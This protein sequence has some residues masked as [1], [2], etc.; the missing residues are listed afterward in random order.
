MQKLRQEIT[1]IILAYKSTHIIENALDPIVNQGFNIK[2]IDNGSNDNIADLLKEKYANSGI[3]LIMLENNV[4]FSRG[5][6]VALKKVTT[7][8]AFLLN[9]D[10]IIDPESID[11]LALEMEKDKNIAL[12][13]PFS[14]TNLDLTLEEK[15]Q[16]I[17]N[18][19]KT[20]T[21]LNED[22]NK[23]ETDFICGGYMLIKT[24]I[25]QKIGFLDENLFLYYDDNEISSRSI[26]NNYKNILIKNS[27]TVHSNQ[28]SVKTNNKIQEYKMIYFRS[29]HMGWSKS[30][31]KNNKSNFRIL[32]KSFY[33]IL[34]SVK[35]L[36]RLDL[37][38]FIKKIGTSIG[39]ISNIIGLDCFNKENKI[40]KVKNSYRI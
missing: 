6:N 31:I 32:I 33:N 7:K 3:E 39:S 25:F 8:Y 22:D 14:I 27:Y 34:T 24:K 10:A 29:W 28:N 12:A 18:Y 38:C 16:E 37:N 5:N 20:I 35:E 36:I 9:P 40:V 30:Y 26:K 15:A 19:K 17:E 1:I 4:G 23:I 13:S 2:V 21:I 11:N